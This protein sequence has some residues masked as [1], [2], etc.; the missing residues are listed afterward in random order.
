MKEKID[1]DEWCLIFGAMRYFMGRATIASATFPEAVIRKYHARLSE[2]QKE[3]LVEDLREH[4][5]EGKTFGWKTIDEPVWNKFLAA[6]DESSHYQVEAID[7]TTHT[8]F[9]ANGKIYPLNTY[10]RDPGMEIYLPEEN[11]LKNRGNKVIDRIDN[12]K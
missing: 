3:Q 4:L 8:V 1:I 5:R 9:E 11:I 6:L 2:V 7:N 10:L 12:R